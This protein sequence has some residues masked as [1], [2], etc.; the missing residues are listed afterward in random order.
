MGPLKP[1]VLLLLL[2]LLLLLAGD[3]DPSNTVSMTKPSEERKLR[4]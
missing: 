4:K 2:L 1:M 3:D